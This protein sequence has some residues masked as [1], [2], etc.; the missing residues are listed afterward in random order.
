MSQHD[1]EAREDRFESGFAQ[2]KYLR[3]EIATLTAE[4]DAAVARAEKAEELARDYAQDARDIDTE[5]DTAREQVARLREALG[6]I[7]AMDKHS[8]ASLRERAASERAR[9][10]LA[11]T[12][13][14]ETKT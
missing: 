13:T 12:R 10:A 4:R 6:E 5:C 14:K 2:I 8:G 1:D 11:A 9:A 7:A 3:A